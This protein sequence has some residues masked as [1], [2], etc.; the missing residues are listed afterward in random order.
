MAEFDNPR[1]SSQPVG[2]TDQEVLKDNLITFDNVINSSLD[3]ITTRKGSQFDT[4]TGYQNK[5]NGAIQSAGGTPLNNGIWAAGQTFTAYN[6]FMIYSGVAYKPLVT[7]VL[8]Y[9]PT[10]ATPDIAFVQPFGGEGIT[11]DVASKGEKQ[12]INIS[13]YP[14]EFDK[15]AS[16]S[17]PYNTA[18]AGTEALR[19]A[20]GDKIYYTSE[21]VSGM[22]TAIDFSG[23]TATVGGV[24]VTLDVRIEIDSRNVGEYTNYTAASVAD[25][26]AGRTVG[27][28][29]V[30]HEIGQRWRIYG[31]WEVISIS[32]PMTIA[33][34]TSYGYVNA[35]DFGVV[36]DYYLFNGSI[37]PTP[38]DNTQAI[39]DA[40]SSRYAARVYLPSNK[41]TGVTGYAHSDVIY[42]DYGDKLVGDTLVGTKLIKTTNNIGSGSFT[43]PDTTVIPFTVDASIIKRA[44]GGSSSL[45]QGI[46]NLTMESSVNG[47]YGVYAAYMSETH[48]KDVTI[49]GFKRGYYSYDQFLCS[50]DRVWVRNDG[51]DRGD[52][53]FD[54]FKGTSLTMNGCWAKRIIRGYEFNQLQYSIVNAACDDFTFFAYNGGSSITYTSIGMEEGN[55]TEG[56]FVIGGGAREIFITGGQLGTITADPGATNV[57]YFKFNGANVSIDSFRLPTLGSEAA[58]KMDMFTLEGAA[59]VSFKGVLPADSAYRDLVTHATNFSLLRVDWGVNGDS[60]YT[61]E[62]S[63]VTIGAKQYNQST[64]K[65]GKS[66]VIG[67]PTDDKSKP[68]NTST[69]QIINT[70]EITSTPVDVLELTNVSGNYNLTVEIDCTAIATTTTTIIKGLILHTNGTG[71]SL[72]QSIVLGSTHTIVA[73]WAGD[74]LQISVGNGADTG[75]VEVRVRTRASTGNPLIR[76]L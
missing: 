3:S 27:L 69:T 19:D 65:H 71:G 53:G 66:A 22:I 34:F 29:V 30:P 39:L 5:V 60:V 8:P 14:I 17:A 76:W 44:T 25:M 32:N 59:N 58:T 46:E 70:Y 51:F 49:Q 37:N 40:L 54:F 50:M 9:G 75:V 55:L 43:H 23:G 1:P 72:T 26:I 41:Y 61:K 15:S 20:V 48:D 47:E 68:L 38:T 56:G 18:P 4:L 10:G 2:S 57:S 7:T 73:T 6:Q 11:P 63:L 21:I 67:Y 31:D 45:N 33:D 13:V 52:I 36:G 42:L 62:Q 64:F 28:D 12:Q 24:A 35:K 74:K 16:T